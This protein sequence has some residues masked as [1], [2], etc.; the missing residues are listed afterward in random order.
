MEFDKTNSLLDRA[1]LLV[2]S[3]A[4]LG[5]KINMADRGRLG[6]SLTQP[7][8]LERARLHYTLPRART[9]GGEVVRESRVVDFKSA[10]REIDFG[11]NYALPLVAAGKGEFSAF[12]EART[13]GIN[14]NRFGV[15]FARQF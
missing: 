14:E 6:F 3:T 13:G 8:T 7:L 4:S 2:T 5:Y 9:L 11:V 1:E 12:A 10:Q 15:K